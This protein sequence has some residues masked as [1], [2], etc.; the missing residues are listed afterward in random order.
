MRPNACRFFVVWMIVMSALLLPVF[1]PAASQSRVTTI[2]EDERFKKAIDA[3][4]T[5]HEKSGDTVLAGRI[6]QWYAQGYIKLASKSSLNFPSVG[7]SMDGGDPYYWAPTGTIYI[8]ESRLLAAVKP[9]GAVDFAAIT[10]LAGSMAHEM[11]HANDEGMLS[12]AFLTSKA[13][14]EMS[15][16]TK[17]LQSYFAGAF[18]RNADIQKKQGG[19][20]DKAGDAQEVN[21]MIGEFNR[22]FDAEIAP[23]NSARQAPL[24]ARLKELLPKVQQAE[25]A[26][27]EQLNKNIGYQSL[28]K[29]RDAIS[30]EMGMKLA[31]TNQ[32]SLASLRADDP[33][34]QELWRRIG[35]NE[36]KRKL[37]ISSNLDLA[38]FRSVAENW[39][40][41][42]NK[43]NAEYENYLKQ[44]VLFPVDTMRIPRLSY[45]DRHMT[46]QLHYERDRAASELQRLQKD[47]SHTNEIMQR[48]SALQDRIS[49]IDRQLQTV[50]VAEARRELETLRAGMNAIIEAC[51]KEKK[52]QQQTAKPKEDDLLNC[53]CVACGGTLGGYHSK[54]GDCAG[55]CTCW[56]PLSGWCTPIPTDA[57]HAR[58]CYGSAY[59]VKDPSEA[60]V[61]QVLAKAR[62]ENTKA[63]EAAI[64]K[65]LKDKRLDDAFWIGK[66]AIKRDPAITTPALGELTNE[67]K[68]Q[69]WDAL[70]KADHPTA[71]KRLE[72]ATLISP[73]DAD[74]AKKLSDAKHSAAQWPRVLEKE[75]EFNELIAAKKV[76]SAHRTMLQ[77]QD[78]LRPL[79]GGQSSENPVWKS[80]NQ[81]LN[82]GIKWYNEFTQAS[83]A[84]WTRLFKAQEWEQAETHVKRVLTFEL[85]PADKRH[86]DSALQLVNSMLSGR[87]EAE[88]YYEQAKA[89]FAKGI[90]ADTAGLG[91]VVRELKN[92]EG[93]FNPDDPRRKRIGA[94]AIDM[95]KRQKVL[96]AKAYAQIHFNNGD[97]Y[98]R[99]YNFEPAAGQYAEGLRAIRENGDTSDPLYAKYYKLWEDS[100]AKDKRFKELYA[101]AAGLAMTDKTLDEA[102]IQKGID[103]AE[104]G[105]KIRPRNGDMEIHWNKLKWK[106]G[107]LKRKQ[108]SAQACEAKWTDGK[109]L[110]NAGKHAEALGK[111]RENI[112]CAPGNR[113]R[114]GY[115]KQLEDSL[116]KQAA[117]KQA[118][119][120]VRQ[121]GD[122]LVQQKKYADA[123]ARYRESL[124]CQ[125]DQ[126]LEEYVRT[127]E[128]TIKQ[129]GAVATQ[130]PSG[131]SVT[132]TGQSGSSQSV[133]SASSGAVLFDNGNIGGVSNGPTQAT[134]FSLQ[135]KATVT[136]I[137]T[138]HWNGG[139]GAAPG[140]IGLRNQSGQTYGPWSA[141]G[142][143]GQGGVQNAN[144]HV[145][146]NITLPAGTYTVVVSQP[147]T[148]AHNEQSQG[149]GFARIEGSFT[150]NPGT[151]TSS[152]VAGPGR[153][154]SAKLTN[155]GQ[156]NV[157][158]YIDGQDT[159]GPQN[160]LAPGQSKTLTFAP[161]A[162]GRVK[163]VFSR[164]GRWLGSC[165]WEYSTDRTPVIRFTEEGGKPQPVC[166]THLQ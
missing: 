69:G 43:A 102:T 19:P 143:P 144:W 54:L 121:Q 26:F 146:P 142:S 118:C 109:V 132:Q 17:T 122:S 67:L 141:S 11:V 45:D 12:R 6:R 53:L 96:N 52:G 90:P 34:L 66:E 86:Y 59:G 31:Q 80:V 41:Q 108:Q 151:G 163:F 156:D 9:T 123:I 145:Y 112:A 115:V 100:L 51:D 38:Q 28:L 98:Y 139:R 161:P 78:I 39:R 128:G 29:E 20:C 131:T 65:A 50:T 68:K 85:T 133:T 64:R 106:L 164:G 160:R 117:A 130:S 61:Q 42:Y 44:D 73:R 4:I 24:E 158:I 149:R 114:E 82:N 56:G 140:T 60:D 135:Q 134:V 155:N 124:R 110:F 21:K 1:C 62:A 71:I 157:H 74:A 95:E 91:A 103:A 127:L 165:Y 14:R 10:E 18:K 23:K 138:Y 35:E 7:I 87:R 119:L 136:K 33:S 92:R 152:S 162:S 83:N 101:Y 25:K 125:P 79:A 30:Y 27:E 137:T 36:R 105:L 148:W 147:S 58:N 153:T 89:N 55:G 63:T 76:W 126:K 57:K 5:Y 94:L 72:Q 104:E 113:E 159:A 48:I 99:A 81:S 120:S 154:V 40:Q 46:A 107:E 16:Y 13:E 37:F 84:E 49:E 93:R 77:M 15:A 75:K 70:H 8:P 111:F 22:Y 116:H 32:Y 47:P 88:Q 3:I 97:M 150:P 166:T 129:Q 2:S